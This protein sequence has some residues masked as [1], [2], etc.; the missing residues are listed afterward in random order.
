VHTPLWQ[1]PPTE[2]PPPAAHFGQLLPPQSV[3]VSV[4]FL[5]LSEQVAARHLKSVP[6]TELTQSPLVVQIRP[7]LHFG[8]VAPPQ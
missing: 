6:Q 4:P 2:H 1:S 5:T 3:P 8:Q 7:A